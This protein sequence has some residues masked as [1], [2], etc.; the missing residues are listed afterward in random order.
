MSCDVISGLDAITATVVC[1][2]MHTFNFC[3]KHDT[4]LIMQLYVVLWYLVYLI[5]RQN[6][7]AVLSTISISGSFCLFSFL[8]NLN[9]IQLCDYM[10]VI[11]DGIS[12]CS[13]VDAKVMCFMLVL[14]QHK[15]LL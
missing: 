14:R 9:S 5:C 7:H 3:L 11:S 10:A 1:M 13:P 4:I 8:C 15:L 6:G 2:Y 12:S